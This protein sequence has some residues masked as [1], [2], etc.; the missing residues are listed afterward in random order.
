[1]SGH[2]YWELMAVHSEHQIRLYY[3]VLSGRCTTQCST[4]VDVCVTETESLRML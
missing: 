2:N 4:N 1:M 3:S